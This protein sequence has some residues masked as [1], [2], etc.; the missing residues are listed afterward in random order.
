M[1]RAEGDTW[2]IV[3]SVGATALLV[4]ALRAAEARKPEPLACDV[5]AQ[6]FVAATKEAIPTFSEVVENPAFAAEPSV[7]LY[8]SYLGARTRYFDEYFL[9]AGAA[10]IRQAVI[11]ASGLDVRGYRLRWPDETTMYELDRPK[12]LAF[13]KQI[14]DQRG[15]AQ[16]AQVRAVPV[17]LRDDW[18]AALKAAGFDTDAPTAWLAEGLLSYLPGAAQDLLF[19]RIGGLSAPGSR[20]AVE[21]FQAPGSQVNQLSDGIAQDGAL[22]RIFDSIVEEGKDVSSLLF[23]DE[24]EDP[25]RWLTAHGWTVSATNARELLVRY[26]RSPLTGLSQFTDA[27]GDSRYFTAIKSA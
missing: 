13:K 19:Q 18:P 20:V 10:G 25:A 15:A 17:D 3:S 26:N 8:S 7:E 4:S 27:L 22:R 23:V 5:Y 12:V 24:R 11:L 16:T 14:L 6:Y 2:D 9:E 1:V 21:D